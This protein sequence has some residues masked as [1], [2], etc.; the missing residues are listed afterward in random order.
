MNATFGSCTLLDGRAR[1]G[2]RSA[3]SRKATG[4][5]DGRRDEPDIEVRH[6]GYYAKFNLTVRVDVD[7]RCARESESYA[8]DADAVHRTLKS[9]R[10]LPSR[11]GSYA[12]EETSTGDLTAAS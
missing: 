1:R 9:T 8:F 3:T 7:G 4:Y 12:H 10:G 2:R 11:L 6:D 5:Q